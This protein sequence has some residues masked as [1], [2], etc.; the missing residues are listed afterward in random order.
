MVVVNADTPTL[1]LNERRVNY[2]CNEILIP[3]IRLAEIKRFAN[4]LREEGCGENGFPPS[5]AM[6]GNGRWYRLLRG[7]LALFTTME[8]ACTLGLEFYF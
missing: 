2:N 6:G 5:H 1:I 7:N 3:A 4:T 8:S